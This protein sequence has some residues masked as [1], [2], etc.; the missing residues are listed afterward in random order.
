MLAITIAPAFH[1]LV[2]APQAAFFAELFPTSVRYSGASIGYQVASIAAG[3]PAPLIAVGVLQHDG[4]KT[5][6]LLAIYLGAAAADPTAAA[7]VTAPQAA[8]PIANT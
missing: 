3:A 2:Y 6:T 8:R 5:P 1:G 4:S 7:P